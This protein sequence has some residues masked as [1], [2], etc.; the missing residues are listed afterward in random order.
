MNDFQF[1]FDDLIPLNYN[2][3]NQKLISELEDIFENTKNIIID[4][5]IREN[6]IKKLGRICIGDSGKSEMFIRFFN[7]EIISNLG[8]QLADLRSS[9]MK[10]ACRIVSL[11]CKELGNSAE[12]GAAHLLSKTILFKIAGSANRVIADSSSKCILNLVKYVNTP[13][14]INNVCEQKNIKSN[15]VRIICTQCILYIVSCYKK[16]LLLNKVVILQDTIKDLLGDPN[17]DVRA[18]IRKAF[19]TFRKRLPG[20]GNNIF[21]NLEKNVQ[22]QIHEDEKTYGHKIIIDENFINKKNFELSPIKKKAKIYSSANKPKSHEIKL[23]LKEIP[24]IKKVN[25]NNLNN[26]Q[27]D[28][29]NNLNNYVGEEENNTT[30]NNNNNLSNILN[31]KGSSDIIDLHNSN[32]KKKYIYISAQGIKNANIYSNQ[33]TIRIDHKDLLKKLNEKFMN[34]NNENEKIINKEEKKDNFLPPINQFNP[35][36]NK[37]QNCKKGSH[38]VLQ[39]NKITL[40]NGVNQNNSMAMNNNYTPII[41]DNMPNIKIIKNNDSIEKKLIENMNKISNKI[42]INEK[43]KIFQFIFNNFKDILNEYKNYTTNTLRLLINIH[44]DNMNENNTSLIEQI[45]KNIMRLLFYMCQILTNND[46]QLIVKLLIQKINLGDN[47]ISNLCYKLLDLIRKKG[48]I[49][50]IYSGIFDSFEKQ[51]LHINDICYEYLAY[52]V[53]RYGIIF[54]SNSYYERLFN[55]INNCNENSKKIGKLIGALYKNDKDHFIKLYKGESNNNQQKIISIIE[56]NN[57]KFIQELKQKIEMNKI[58]DVDNFDKSINNKLK[59]IINESNNNNINKKNINNSNLNNNSINSNT[60]SEEIKIN[61]ENGNIKLFISYIENNINY[62][63][64][65]IMILSNEKHSDYK[66]TKNYLNFIYALISNPKFNKEISKN[67][68]IL[69]E[70]IINILQS[71]KNDSV[72]INS[73]KEIL[74]I[75]PNKINSDKYFKAIS[76]YLNDKSDII[77]LQILLGSIKNYIIYDKNKNLERTMTYFI[78]GVLLLLDY[79]SSDIRKSAIYCC[80]E[81]YNILKDKFNIYY[82]RMSKNTQNIINQLIKKKVG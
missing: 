30:N 9:V 29:D 74:Y 7:T 28:I 72:I 45:L 68:K 47:S 34:D 57:L 15:F 78:D 71:N 25:Y 44:T 41:K 39:R 18:T 76:I 49:E 8:I 38:S 60:I 27:I 48:K 42:D 3:L 56:S 4:W 61:L 21:N 26:N 75:L 65:F 19:I 37:S 51:D 81:M 67:M 62:I 52:L 55:L 82:E 23:K 59:K 6:A 16:N 63:P 14:I 73:I 46:I 54:E 1:I 69:I 22:K 13:R 17:G 77:L 2:G 53:N 20:E 40:Q 24:F 43:I 36:L 79:Q 66:I 70:Q 10:E 50:D 5:Q 12:P 80:V 11:C 32:N 33:N 58:N 31:R 64:S 35:S